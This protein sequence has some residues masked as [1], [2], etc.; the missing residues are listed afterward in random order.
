MSQKF[1]S[2]EQQLKE[3][4]AGKTTTS[5]DSVKR[6]TRMPQRGQHRGS[7][8]EVGSRR[9][10]TNGCF[11]CEEETH[12]KRECPL[13]FSESEPKVDGGGRIRK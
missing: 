11:L 3:L 5:H 1:E 7:S 12:W 8:Q 10:N 4:D 9:K 6:D 13:N 2:F